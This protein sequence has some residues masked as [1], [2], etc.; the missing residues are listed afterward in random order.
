MVVGY[1]KVVLDWFV[2][3]SQLNSLNLQLWMKKIIYLKHNFSWL[4]CFHVHRQFN[5][6]EG[7]LSK[8]DLGK[9]LSW[10]LFEEVIEDSVIISGSFFI[11]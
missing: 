10:L 4:K 1:S 7:S 6:M 11:L 8:K 9:Q 5:S 2:G 3:K